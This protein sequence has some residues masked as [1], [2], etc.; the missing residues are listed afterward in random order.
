MY[1]EVHG[2]GAPLILLHGGLGS[3]GMFNPILPALSDGRKVNAVDLQGHGRTADIDRPIR[4]ETMGDDIAGLIRQLD[5]GKVDIMGYS[6]GGGVG[7]R[8]AIQHPDLVK[9]LVIVS[10]PYSR[11]GY[12]SE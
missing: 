3:S 6:M 2:E 11:E 1:Y 12:F 8:T 7:L 5:L 4:P 10:V 9:R